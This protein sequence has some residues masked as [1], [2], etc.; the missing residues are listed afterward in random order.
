MINAVNKKMSKTGYLPLNMSRKQE[1]YKN[2]KLKY[3][4]KNFKK[5]LQRVRKERERF[6][7]ELNFI[8]ITNPEIV[9]V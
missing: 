5:R 6:L 7:E 1:R 9:T 2:R 3:S 8:F 4:E